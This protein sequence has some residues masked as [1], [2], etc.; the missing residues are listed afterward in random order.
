M[1]KF[2]VLID[3]H[4][5]CYITKLMERTQKEELEFSYSHIS[6]IAMSGRIFLWMMASLDTSQNLKR[7]SLG[8]RHP[9]KEKM[10]KCSTYLLRCLSVGL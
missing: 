1:F 5:L 10:Q 9:G 4:H 3:D 6:F 2:K 7:K 8:D